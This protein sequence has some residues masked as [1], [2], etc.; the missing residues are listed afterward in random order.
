M[1]KN[2][3][4]IYLSL[5]GS[6]S[7]QRSGGGGR[8]GAAGRARARARARARPRARTAA[9]AAA[10]PRYVHNMVTIYTKHRE[11]FLANCLAW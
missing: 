9:V 1:S 3:K 4:T 6:G 11:G 7:Q 5:P 10:T 8:A 2:T